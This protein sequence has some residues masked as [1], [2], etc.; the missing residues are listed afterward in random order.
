MARM[1][2]RKVWDRVY[3]SCCNG[4]RSVKVERGREKRQMAREL[5]P[6]ALLPTAEPDDGDCIHGCNG[7]CVY[8]GSERCNFTCHQLTPH[9]EAV[10]D[11]LDR[12]AMQL[13]GEEMVEFAETS[14]P[15]TVEAAE[16]VGVEWE[17]SPSN[18]RQ[19]A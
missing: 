19:I 7:G 6:E 16:L 11:R 8:G 5:R 1:L 10:F 14:L 4:P 12:R 9:E 2:G 15:L 13:L 17:P 3:C 18:D